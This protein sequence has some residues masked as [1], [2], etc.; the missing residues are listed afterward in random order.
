ML[1]LL[2]AGCF[3]AGWCFGAAYC[4]WRLGD[5]GVDPDEHCC[6][7]CMEYG[8]GKNKG[9]VTRDQWG[10]PLKEKD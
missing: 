10:Y 4:M 3:A 8:V 6:L 9:T 2:G 1:W 5:T 7:A